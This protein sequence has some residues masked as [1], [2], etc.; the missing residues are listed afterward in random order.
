MGISF[1]TKERGINNGRLGLIED[2]GLINSW[3]EGGSAMSPPEM[4]DTRQGRADF[5]LRCPFELAGDG[6]PDRICSTVSPKADDAQP[7]SRG[8][9]EIT[10][11]FCFDENTYLIGE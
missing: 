4:S 2:H 6:S 1:T 10:I 9:L 7:M 3:Q 8:R 11:F 5:S